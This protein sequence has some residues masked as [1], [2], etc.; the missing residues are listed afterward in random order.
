[1]YGLDFSEFT[2]AVVINRFKNQTNSTTGNNGSSAINSSIGQ[3]GL[4]LDLSQE[5]TIQ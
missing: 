5:F 4:Q 2:V 1:V 3:I